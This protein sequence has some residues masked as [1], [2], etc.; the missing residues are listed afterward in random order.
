VDGVEHPDREG[1]PM[2]G[3]APNGPYVVAGGATLEDA[4]F[5]EGA[6]REHFTLCRCGASTNKPFCSGAHWNVTFDEHASSK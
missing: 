3:I 5:G 1:E 4:A 2:I 6:S